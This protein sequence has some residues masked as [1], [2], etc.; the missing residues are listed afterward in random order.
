MPLVIIFAFR[1]LKKCLSGE[2]AVTSSIMNN[3][4]QCSLKTVF[5]FPSKI[6]IRSDRQGY[7]ADWV[8]VSLVR[9]QPPRGE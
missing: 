4:E 9:A 5:V 8:A 7:F 2:K 6:Y 1:S 3:Y